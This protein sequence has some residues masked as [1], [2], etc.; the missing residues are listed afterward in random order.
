MNDKKY[1]ILVAEDDVD[2][3]SLLRLYLENANYEVISAENGKEALLAVENEQ[4][5]LFICDIMMPKMSGYEVI[6]TIR[7]R[8]NNIPILVLSAKN[9]D[10]DRILGLD[11][12]ADDYMVK[13]F[14]PLEIVARANAMLR[15]FY[16]LG[17][18]DM[19]D[20]MTFTVGELRLDVEKARFSKKNE[21]ILLTPTEFKIMTLLMKNPGR[22]FTKVQIYEHVNGEYY[23]NDD[24]TLM[25][26]MSKLR[27]KIEDDSKNPRYIKTVRGLG[28]K[29]DRGL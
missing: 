5:N 17:S 10:S 24:N 19:S 18:S 11:I 25:V 8:G 16:K 4:P 28:Y 15:R 2:I 21:E 1:K 14:N 23:E 7:D 6:K 26:H 20:S 9:Q 13:P 29:L 22:V 27:D 12:G 3:I